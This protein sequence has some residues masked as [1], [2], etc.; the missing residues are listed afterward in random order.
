MYKVFNI[1]TKKLIARNCSYNYAEQLASELDAEGGLV[2]R[3]NGSLAFICAPTNWTLE[4]I[5]AYVNNL[6]KPDW[7]HKRRWMRNNRMYYKAI[8]QNK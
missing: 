2:T 8:T 3:Q 6:P 1:T 4:Q 5:E 7:R